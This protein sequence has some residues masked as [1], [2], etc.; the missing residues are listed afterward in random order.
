MGQDAFLEGSRGMPQWRVYLAWMVT[1]LL[2]LG[3]GSCET[4]IPEGVLL[5][6]DD[7]DCPPAWSCVR[8]EDRCF[9]SQA[10]AEAAR[11]DDPAKD[12][13]G[14][15]EGDAGKFPAS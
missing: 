13:G 15:A 10:A 14:A 6:K 3:L 5:C 11:E 7:G 12:D 8:P 4:E 1:V 9:S 2:G